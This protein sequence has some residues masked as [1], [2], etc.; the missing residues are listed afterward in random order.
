MMMRQGGAAMAVMNTR[1][2]RC[3]LEAHQQAM[4]IFVACRHCLISP[5]CHARRLDAA[6]LRC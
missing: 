1:L 2:P 4:L 5:P 3:P 6:M